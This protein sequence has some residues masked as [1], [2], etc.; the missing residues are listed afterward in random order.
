MHSSEKEGKYLL[1]ARR[2]LGTAPGS[3]QPL[4]CSACSLKPPG[5]LS[6]SLMLAGRGPSGRNPASTGLGTDGQYISEVLPQGKSQGKILYPQV[7]EDI[8]GWGAQ[9]RRRAATGSCL[10]KSPGATGRCSLY[11]EPHSWASGWGWGGGAL[12]RMASSRTIST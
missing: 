9:T 7:L 11:T 8:Q 1:N 4:L 5:K 12:V 6:G 3:T 10:R 2:M